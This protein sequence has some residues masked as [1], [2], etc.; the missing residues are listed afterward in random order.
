[1][2]LAI[3][4]FGCEFEVFSDD[5]DFSL[6]TVELID[7]MGMTYT[8]DTAAVQNVT[9]VMNAKISVLSSGKYTFDG[10]TT[11]TETDPFIPTLTASMDFP[12]FEEGTL[13]EIGERRYRMMANAGGDPSEMFLV[14][15]EGT[16]MQMTQPMSKFGMFPAPMDSLNRMSVRMTMSKIATN[17]K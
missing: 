13:E 8:L 14:D 11:I 4:A 10:K 16:G 2:P 12:Q 1:M 15:E 6:D 7:P 9:I 17:T 5:S 3:A